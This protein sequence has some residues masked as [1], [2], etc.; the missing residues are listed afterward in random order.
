M[1]KGPKAQDHSEKSG[2]QNL[3]K[4]RKKLI[5]KIKERYDIKLNI[6][7]YSELVIKKHD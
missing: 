2:I 6:Q 1:Q 5:S 4:S 3:M 7:D